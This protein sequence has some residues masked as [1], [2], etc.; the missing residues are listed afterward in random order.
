MGKSNQIKLDGWG[1]AMALDGTTLYF[2]I[3][4]MMNKVSLSGRDLHPLESWPAEIL[5]HELQFHGISKGN[6]AMATAVPAEGKSFHGVLFRMTDEDMAKLDEI[7]SG[8]DRC[9]AEARKYDGQKVPCTVYRFNKEE[10]RKM[11]TMS[12][13][14]QPTGDELP[15]ERYIDIL[16]RGALSHGVAAEHIEWLQAHPCRPRKKMD[17]FQRFDRTGLDSKPRMKLSD[18]DD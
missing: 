4:A 6:D 17:E 1:E 2:A 14:G 8:Y 12:N 16:S 15:S 7:E 11:A 3:G 13:L 5:D 10:V 18:L 9:P